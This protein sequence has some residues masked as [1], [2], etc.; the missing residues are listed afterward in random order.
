MVIILISDNP[1]LTNN[2]SEK[3]QVLSITTKKYIPISNLKLNFYLDEAEDERPR[4]LARF[5]LRLF[6]RL[7]FEDLDDD[8]EDPEE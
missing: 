1:L 6:D 3:S 5:G 2:A 8:L 7:V 4:R